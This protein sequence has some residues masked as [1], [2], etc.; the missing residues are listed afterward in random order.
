MVSTV[1]APT[2]R[3]PPGA[4]SQSL[5]PGLKFA[6]PKLKIV[7]LFG[8]PLIGLSTKYAHPNSGMSTLVPVGVVGV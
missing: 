2:G 7:I 5:S 6:L 4:S 8:C 1:Y 3:A